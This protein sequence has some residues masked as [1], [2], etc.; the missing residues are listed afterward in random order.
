MKA[1]QRSTTLSDRRRFLR[2]AGATAAAAA[3]FAPPAIAAAAAA[4]SITDPCLV[5]AA[6]RDRL[7]TIQQALE[8]RCREICNANPPMWGS[9]WPR[10]DRSL[11]VFKSTPFEDGARVARGECEMKPTLRW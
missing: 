10:V 3:V 11:A 8:A 5:I 7:R 6:E 2:L 1:S 4:S 9:G